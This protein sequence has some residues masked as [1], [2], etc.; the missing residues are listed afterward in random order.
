MKNL[1][2]KWKKDTLKNATSYIRPYSRK[3]STSKIPRFCTRKPLLDE[4][5]PPPIMHTDIFSNYVSMVHEYISFVK[6]LKLLPWNINYYTI[7]N[8]TNCCSWWKAWNY[9]WENVSIIHSIII[10]GGK[11]DSLILMLQKRENNKL[12][13][14][15]YSNV[16]N[17]M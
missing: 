9:L 11:L 16:E 12:G 13:N 3:I 8:A 15:D 17:F 14:N 5:P 4:N 2:R 7:F 1:I 6:T 10:M